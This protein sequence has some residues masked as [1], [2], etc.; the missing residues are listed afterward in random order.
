MAPFHFC[1]PRSPQD[2]TTPQY[3]EK[4]THTDQYLHWD[5]NHF[6]KA[7]NSVYNTLAHRAKVV[8]SNPTA[9]SKELDHI[10]RALQSCLFPTWALNRLQ[11]NFEHKHNN[12][13][14]P[15]LTDNN[16]NGTTDHNKQRNIS[17]VVPYIQG[18]VSV[19]I[20]LFKSIIFKCVSVFI[21]LL[22]S[23]IKKI[24]LLYHQESGSN[25]KHPGHRE[26]Y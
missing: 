23:I 4:P 9:L 14:D 11:H 19:F 1:T 18:C 7:K 13:R 22:K 3:T 16:T 25:N 20:P 26:S 12:N 5:S 6:N 24:S 21:P 15:N 10:R 17:M 2:P 8:S